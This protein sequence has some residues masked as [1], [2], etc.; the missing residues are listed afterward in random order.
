MAEPTRTLQQ[1]RRDICGELRMPFFLLFDNYSTMTG[2]PTTTALYDSKLTQPDDYWNGDSI[3][4][5]DGNAGGNVRRVADFK[6]AT[7]EANPEFAFSAT[8]T[9]G[10]KY[11]I[12]SR[13][14]AF[15]I[16]RAI[17]SAIREG[18]DAFAEYPIDESLI[19]KE[20]TL[21]YPLTITARQVLKL[22]V[23]NPASASVQGLASGGA[24]TYLEDLDAVFADDAYNAWKISIYAGTGAG[25][26]RVV[27]DTVASTHRILV[28]VNWTVSPDGTSKYLVWNPTQQLSEWTRLNAARFYPPDFPTTM[29]LPGSLDAF[30]GLRFRIQYEK[31]PAELSGEADT[32]VVDPSYIMYR[33]IAFLHSFRAGDN[34]FDRATHLQEEER[35]IK[36]AQTYLAERG[37]RGPSQ[38]FWQ[39]SDTRGG[40]AGPVND[41]MGW[42]G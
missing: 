3:Y 5:I 15:E 2:T 12:H 11:E 29:Y 20:D 38:T 13:W 7:D 39:E 9:S 8:P 33:A 30:V 22:W 18:Y 35:Y 34:R 40:G 27:S 25:Q 41:P 19:V 24:A 10:D 17:N 42:R 4:V 32:T 28:S 37:H 26:I 16:R 21:E 1:L 36:K 6:A 14:N 23:E 31:G